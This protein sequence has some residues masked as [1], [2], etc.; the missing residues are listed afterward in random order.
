M[1]VIVSPTNSKISFATK[2]QGRAN[3][4]DLVAIKVRVKDTNNAPIPSRAVEIS[5]EAAGVIITQPEPTGADG[6]AIGYAKS[7]TVGPVIFRARVLPDVLD[8]EDPGYLAGSVWVDNTATAYFYD[9]DIDPSP[10]LQPSARN[11]HLTWSVSRYFMNS[12][13]GIR[14]RIE[15]DDSNLMPT[16]IFAYQLMPVRPGE[17]EGVGAFDHVCSSVDLEEYPEDAPLVNSRPQWFRMDYVDVL[18]RSREEVREFIKSVVEDVQI[19]KNTL[20]VTEDIVSAGDLWIG[21]APE[22]G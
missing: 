8:P 17:L 11:V 15:A 13:D 10:P 12:I 2:P 3:N 1:P 5:T 19:L 21:A 9:E 20:D 16:K 4:V 6:L 7:N 14:V 22:E 18:L